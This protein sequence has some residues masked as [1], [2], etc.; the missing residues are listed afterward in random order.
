LDKEELYEVFKKM[1]F[2]IFCVSG[3]STVC[4]LN[5]LNPFIN[6][7]IGD[8][9]ILPYSVI[10]AITINFFLTQS[11]WLVITFKQTAGIF[12][13]DMYKPLIEVVFNLG[14]S[15]FLVRHY[16]ILGVVIATLANTILVCIGTEAYILHKHLFKCSVWIYAKTYLIQIL[17]LL[18]ACAISFYINNFADNFIF[19]CLISILVSVSVYFL[20]FFRSKEF[21][22]FVEIAK[23]MVKR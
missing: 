3:I 20:F 14:L 4:L 5:L 1:S 9:Y 8:A 22:Y 21:A 12:R 23:K 7:W 16:G 10:A 15:I 18:A 11:R 6:L 19:R 13:P 17:A 2:L